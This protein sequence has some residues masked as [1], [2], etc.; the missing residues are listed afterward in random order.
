MKKSWTLL[1]L[2]ADPAM[3][4]HVES[5][6]FTPEQLGL[7]GCTVR[8]Q[9]LHGGL[10]DG[11]ELLW[12]DNGSFRVA[13]LPQRGMGL[14]KA[15]LGDLPLG[16]N[17]PV[18]GPVHP[19]FVPLGEPSGLGW[20]DGFDELLCRCGLWSNG[21]PEYDARGVMLHSLHGRIANLPAHRLVVEADTEANELRV[22]GV[23]DECRFHFHKLR[24]SSTLITRPGQPGVR[25]VDEVT[26]LSGNPGQ[27]ELLYH[28]NFGPPLLEPGSRLCAAVERLMPRDSAAVPG[29]DRWHIY[30]EPQAGAAEE[31]YFFQLLADSA[32]LTRT[33]L[34]NAA[35][36]RGISLRFAVEQ[37]PC[38]TLWKN[39][40]AREDGFVTGL[41]PGVNFPNLR[42]FEER[43]GRV[44][45]LAPSETVRFELAIEAHAGATSVARAEQQ[46]AEL[47]SRQAPQIH[48]SPQT[49]WTLV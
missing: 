35:G 7:A 36:D 13:V 43:Q 38:F 30:G 37:L 24:L 40:P 39:A 28:V 3:D 16:W 1:D 4:R 20:L 29:L 18:R 6:N 34:R 32:G 8:Q 2:A 47:Q 9:T 25:I 45:S 33:L 31:A 41:E 44:R 12:I 17:S 42:S 49:D 48:A 23:V 22:T 10:R 21:P 27:M 19:S 5:Q 14:W 26:N 11:V 46:I 15:W